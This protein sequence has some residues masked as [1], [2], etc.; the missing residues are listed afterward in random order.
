MPT[1][2]S[3]LRPRITISKVLVTSGGKVCSKQKEKSV[4]TVHCRSFHVVTTAALPW[5]TGTAVNPLLR[6]AYLN[7]MNR[8]ACQQGNLD[9]S[10]KLGDT[11]QGSVTLVIPWLVDSEDRQELFGERYSFQNEKEQEEHIRSWLRESAK[12]TVEADIPAR[13]GIHIQFYPAK[14]HAKFKS[15]IPLAAISVLIEKEDADVCILEEPEHLNVMLNSTIERWNQKFNHV[16]GVIHTNYKAYLEGELGSLFSSLGGKLIPPQPL[17]HCDKIVKLSATLQKFASEKE[18]VS[19]VH[20]IRGEFLEEGKRRASSLLSKYIRTGSTSQVQLGS[21]EDRVYFI[22]KILWAKGFDKLLALETIFKRATGSYFPIHIYGSGPDQIDVQ[23][24]FMGRNK[25]KRSGSMD[26]HDVDLTAKEMVKEKIGNLL[27]D[28][29]K[30]RFELRRD[31][32]PAFFHGRTDHSN[33]KKD[34]K[35]FVNPSITEVLCTT[36][37]EVRTLT[38]ITLELASGIDSTNPCN[39]SLLFD[40]QALGMNKFVII[41]HHPSNIFFEQF[42]NCLM[43]NNPTEF[44]SNLQYAIANDPRPLSPNHYYALTWEAAT[45]RLYDASI[46]TQRDAHRSKRLVGISR[47]EERAKEIIDGPLMNAV[48]RMIYQN[49]GETRDL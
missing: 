18:I 9:L 3:E 11:H 27:H 22:G 32:I 10:I 45:E 31:E 48:R 5:L 20:G 14:Y 13:G 30:S 25:P 28:I 15:I 33:L 12:L 38:Y 34:C 29:P 19:N 35:I 21:G 6:A 49:D 36:T 2:A 16:V 17:L 41:P 4:A 46:V 23:R 39:V 26:D 43:Y 44:V 24:A 42:P 47:R 37:A 7:Q 1:P 8:R 40:T